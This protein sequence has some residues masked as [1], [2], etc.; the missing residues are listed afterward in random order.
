MIHDD[1]WCEPV[2]AAYLAGRPLALLFDY[3]GTLTPIVAHPSL[4]VLDESLRETLRGLAMLERVHLA[5]ISGR[6]LADV[7]GK[8]RLSGVCFAGSGG[9]EIDLHGKRLSLPVDDDTVR[10]LTAAFDRLHEAAARFAGVWVEPKPIGFAVHHRG[11]SFATMVGFGS[12]F[13]DLMEG[14]PRLRYL[15]VC[16]AYEVSPRNGWDKAIAVR[17]IL[18]HL[19]R[20]ALPVYFGDSLNDEPAM[21]ATRHAGGETVAVGMDEIAS[22]GFRVASPESLHGVLVRFYR[23]LIPARVHPACR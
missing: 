12:F 8:V 14:F 23:S 3:D 9:S 17:E 11:A 10:E 13:H 6:S 15:G 19:P 21:I 5:V 1:E 7:A 2:R 20:G 18:A 16:E 22:A 4:A